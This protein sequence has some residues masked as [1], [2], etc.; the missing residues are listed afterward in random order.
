MP[1]EP[2]WQR[3]GT[4]GPL[5]PTRR[6]SSWK[7]CSEMWATWVFATTQGFRDVAGFSAIINQAVLQ[8]RFFF[9]FL[10]LLSPSSRAVAPDLI[11][12]A[13]NVELCPVGFTICLHMFIRQKPPAHTTLMLLIAWLLASHVIFYLLVNKRAGLGLCFPSTG[14]FEHCLHL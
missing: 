11:S 10:L 7:N 4:V 2:D 12:G 8:V 5:T 13:I 1:R 9:H 6:L 3:R 14:C